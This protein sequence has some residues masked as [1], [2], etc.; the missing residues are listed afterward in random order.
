[1]T[2]VVELPNVDLVAEN[3]TVEPV[4]HD[5]D[6]E[7][8]DGD[9]DEVYILMRV[10]ANGTTK[11]WA[12][13]RFTRWYSNRAYNMQG[14]VMLFDPED[15]TMIMEQRWYINNS[16]Y[17]WTGAT[18]GISLQRY[19]CGLKKGDTRQVHHRVFKADETFR[20]LDCRRTMLDVLTLREHQAIHGHN[21]K[22]Q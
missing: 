10:L 16:G 6:V 19:V 3:A 12:S 17:V 11:E 20:R 13:T 15:K 8:E 22:T 18:L 4:E 14:D 21:P 2:D 5:V 7:D 9:E 1:M